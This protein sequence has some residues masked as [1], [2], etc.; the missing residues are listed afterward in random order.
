MRLSERPFFTKVSYGEDPIRN[1]M[2]GLDVNYRRDMPRLT[3]LV[4]KLPFYNATGPSNIN[5]V[6][7]TH[8]DVYKRQILGIVTMQL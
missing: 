5:A 6:S 3:K 8:L 2:Y 7:Y 4:D 1:A